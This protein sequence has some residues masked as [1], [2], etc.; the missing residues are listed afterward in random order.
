[1][2]RRFDR[3]QVGTTVYATRKR[4]I[5][6]P[7]VL[8]LAVGM[9]ACAKAPMRQG[10]SLSSYENLVPASGS[11]T[12][13]RLKVDAAGLASA[14]TLAIVPTN[15]SQSATDNAP[16][17]KD[18]ALV[19]NTI[20]RA[21]CRNL[22]DQFEIVPLGQRADLTVRASITN[23]VS[24]N[25]T[26]AGVS[27]VASLGSSAVLPVSVPR[28]PIG[29][30]GLSVE[31]EA[32][33][34]DG[35]QKAAM[36]WAKGANSFTNKARVSA[37]GDAYSLAGTFSKDFSKM[38]SSG[39]TPFKMTLSVPSGQ[40]IRASLGGASKYAPCEAFGRHPGIKGI[41][42]SQL[43]LPPGWTDRR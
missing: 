31:A 6:G 16:T 39:K 29:L 30:G 21:L 10:N 3:P 20:D 13:A 33:S 14:R 4:L 34:P 5:A 28:L 2:I 35:G 27:T 18:M 24:T 42:A 40:N 12:R 25:P 8:I 9:T 19:A 36:V 7:I 23:V 37:I 26:V 1:M 22:S 32:L 11:L 38:L 43:G 15:F 41:V 17:G